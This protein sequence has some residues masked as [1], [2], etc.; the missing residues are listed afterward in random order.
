[1]NTRELG[2]FHQD[3]GRIPQRKGDEVLLLLLF[4]GVWVELL[5]KSRIREMKGIERFT[6]ISGCTPT[7][8][9]C[10]KGA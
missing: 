9:W 6:D 4:G 10:M 2:D 5:P 8:K 1:M 3:M 7:A